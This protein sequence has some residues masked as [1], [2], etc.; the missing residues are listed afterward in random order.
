MDL[1]ILDMLDNQI[2][3]LDG[4]FYD[5][6]KLLSDMLDDN[7][8]Y[9]F[10]HKWA[11]SSSSIKLLLQSPKTYH[12]VMQ[13]GSPE[14][15][16]LRDGFLVHLLIL[17][18]EYFHKQIFVDVQSKNTKKYKLA[19]EE[20]GTVYTI[21]EKHDAERLADAFFRNEPAM[22]LI[23]GCKAEYPGVGLV[24]DK[25]F[26]GKADVLADNCIIDLK[27]T[28]DIRKFEKSAYW[29][30]YD[31]QAYIY[32]EIFGVD[33]FQFIVIDK[34]SCDIGISNYVSKDFI[35]SGRDK[36]AYAL[37]VYHDYFETEMTDLDAYY[38]DINL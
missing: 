12:N 18:P 16:P 10:M 25:P 20:H 7:F 22:Q 29:Y 27:T 38:L 14:T 1:I 26:R 31:V 23:K 35:K 37:K 33:N 2:K 9:G 34:S 36:V 21:K 3:L 4:K 11:F 15:Q 6:T 30:S 32:T 17:T 5:K 13:Y 28:S 8:Y 19:Q 24:Q